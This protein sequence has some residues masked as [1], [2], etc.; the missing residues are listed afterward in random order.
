MFHIVRTTVASTVFISFFIFAP[1]AHAANVAPTIAGTPPASVYQG[2]RYVFRPTASDANGDPLRFS[3]VNQPA[4]A[5]FDPATGKLSGWP[6]G[7]GSYGNIQIKVSDG[8]VSKALPAFS[9]T[10]KWNRAPVISGNP[11]ASV[12]ERTVYFFKPVATDADGQKVKFSATGVPAWASFSAAEGS[13]SGTPPVGAA[14]TYSNIVITATD[15]A[16]SASLP[17][18]AITVTPSPVSTDNHAPTISGVPVTAAVV[19]RPYSFK[20]TAAD[21]DNDALTFSI[22]G[23]PAWAEFDASNGTLSGMPTSANVGTY[24]DVKISA[25]DGSLAAALAPFAIT[26]AN[27]SR[28]SVTLNWTAPTQNIDGTALTDLAGYKIFYGTGS[29]QY[30]T[31]LV[32]AGAGNNSV[33]IEDLTQGTWYFSLQ[34]YNN[35]GVVS[36]FAN[37]VQVVL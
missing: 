28:Q 7:T 1:A 23:K 8:Y 34:S 18:F 3:I 35:A 13:I 14:G 16:K 25:S 2:F 29:R 10:V 11:A 30:S 5:Y 19:G 36:D 15:G 12:V 9:I 26:V 6:T 4:W 21:L 24:P 32:L 33:V 22:S 17:S 31:T 37:E 27:A 20:P